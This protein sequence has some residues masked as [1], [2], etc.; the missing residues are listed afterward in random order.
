MKKGKAYWNC[1]NS[2]SFCS[3]MPHVQ[4][5]NNPLILRAP[6][7]SRPLAKDITLRIVAHG[8]HVGMDHNN[9]CTTNTSAYIIYDF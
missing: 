9:T 2:A 4:T 7:H 3:L 5:S 8:I 1:W 6:A